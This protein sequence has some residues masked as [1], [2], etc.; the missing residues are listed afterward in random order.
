MLKEDVDDDGNDEL[1][2]AAGTSELFGTGVCFLLDWENGEIRKEILVDIAEGFQDMFVKDVNRDGKKEILSFWRVGSGVF[3]A[4][5]IHVYDGKK[6]H[7]IFRPGKEHAFDDSYNQGLVEFKDLDADGTDEML[8]WEA[9]P[10]FDKE[11]NWEPHIYKV[12][13]Y[14]WNRKKYEYMRMYTTKYKYDPRRITKKSIGIMGLPIDFEHN[15]ALIEEYKEKLRKLKNNNQVNVKFVEELL[16]QSNL[17]EEEGLHPIAL[18]FANLG[19][20]ASTYLNEPKEVREV[21]IGSCL[22]MI[23]HIQLKQGNHMESNKNFLKSIQHFEKIKDK[24]FLKT[25]LSGIY[26]NMSVNYIG[27]DLQKALYYATAAYDL[28]TEVDKPERGSIACAN[29]GV[30]YSLLRDFP[31][32]LSYHEKALRWDRRHDAQYNRKLGIMLNLTNIG[33]IHRYLGNTNEA[34]RNYKA[35]LEVTHKIGDKTRA[36][37]FYREIGRCYFF[38]HKFTKALGYFQK[39]LLLD[40]PDNI[41]TMEGIIYLYVGDLYLAQ[42]K[43]GQALQNYKK[44]LSLFKGNFVVGSC[45][46]ARFGMGRIFELRKN[47]QRAL[48]EY[49]NAI[50]IMEDMGTNITVDDLK[51]S[52]LDD[53]EKLRLYSQIVLLLC[54]IRQGE[55]ALKYAEASRARVLLN[56]L[57]NH[58]LSPEKSVD[59]G[60]I[61]LAERQKTRLNSLNKQ[62]DEYLTNG[63]SFQPIINPLIEEQEALQKKYEEAL[64]RLKLS[65]SEYTSLISMFPIPI[66]K[67]QALIDE[68]TCIVE[69][70]LTGSKLI[71]WYIDKD[72]CRMLTKDKM[73]YDRLANKIRD[74]RQAIIDFSRRNKFAYTTRQLYDLLIEPV[75]P[76]LTK[77]RICIIP[78]QV[79]HYLPFQV[80]MKNHTYL[81]EEYDIFYCPSY[82]ILK[83]CFEKNTRKKGRIMA[84]GNPDLTLE[85]ATKE[86]KDITSIPGYCNSISFTGK[87]AT[88]KK[89]KQIA[90]NYDILHLATHSYLNQFN[91][92]FSY[93]KLAP[94]EEEDGRLEVHEVFEL[95]LSAYLVTLS[96]C[97]TKIGKLTAGDEIVGLCRAFIYAGTPSVLVSLWEVDDKSTALLMSSFYKNLKIMD[98]AKA[99]RRAQL[100]VMRNHSHPFHWASFL[101]VGDYN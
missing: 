50:Q 58:K 26:N 89:L 32:A 82:S 54:R 45:W 61:S 42:K 16:R 35:G 79:L 20:K 63:M 6:I 70:F 74:L 5:Y 84:L 46:K 53:K 81:I 83:L 98:K 3:L 59:K 2:A 72:T 55:K 23:A 69:Y 93:I 101:L 68:N 34:I 24:K 49:E 1:L 37:N 85:Y 73:C 30:V 60:L 100:E 75:R 36:A 96:A 44:V 90:K 71:I 47:N 56:M 87:T 88:E 57:A 51:V 11:C 99:L 21:F 14:Q 67:I 92:L 13:I 18:Q 94:E 25:I 86:V 31:K 12:Y 39:S 52:F 95:G 48:R 17:L 33:N 40:S 43:C 4:F 77:E 38:A 62:I 78:H 10:D 28:C 91:P 8:I 65:D 41:R 64:V 22:D 27:Y 7:L 29:I 66:E 15:L 9:C 97:N 76:Y 80:L 19:A